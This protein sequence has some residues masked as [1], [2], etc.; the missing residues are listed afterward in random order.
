MFVVCPD[1][2]GPQGA[3][4]L[5]FVVHDIVVQVHERYVRGGTSADLTRPHGSAKV[6]RQ[7]HGRM[8][9]MADR[10]RKLHKAKTRVRQP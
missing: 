2:A 3:S 8:E 7:P 10:V 6:S 4:R 5:R 9:T 1:R